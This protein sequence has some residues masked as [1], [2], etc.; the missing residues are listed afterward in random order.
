MTELRQCAFCGKWKEKT[1]RQ[2]AI[3]KTGK[4]FC[5]RKCKDAHDKKFGN[6]NRGRTISRGHHIIEVARVQAL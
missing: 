5:D 6:H 3:N 2:I 4:F 1:P